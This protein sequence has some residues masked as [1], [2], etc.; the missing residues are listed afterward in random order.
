[1]ILLK[2]K[3]LVEILGCTKRTAYNKLNDYY[4]FNLYDI[5]KIIQYYGIDCNT[6]IATIIHSS[7]DY[8]TRRKEKRRKKNERIKTISK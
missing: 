8:H 7:N 2:E 3:Q 5:M 4:T 1:M 6:A